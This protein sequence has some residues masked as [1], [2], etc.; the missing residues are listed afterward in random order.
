MAHLLSDNQQHLLHRHAAIRWNYLDSLPEAEALSGSCDLMG[1]F[2]NPFA[3]RTT[4]PQLCAATLKKQ[5]RRVFF[6]WPDSTR[7]DRK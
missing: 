5:L 1:T 7:Q 3:M 4:I 2:V 6:P